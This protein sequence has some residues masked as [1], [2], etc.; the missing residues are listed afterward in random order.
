M[1]YVTA[2]TDA[3]NAPY[4]TEYQVL[5]DYYR[6]AESKCRYALFLNKLGKTEQAQRLFQE[7]L[8]Y[9]KDAPKFYRQAQKQW[10]EIAKQHV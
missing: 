5:A 9:A 1:G 2:Q 4:P 10:L 3:P 6:G 8:N 7:M